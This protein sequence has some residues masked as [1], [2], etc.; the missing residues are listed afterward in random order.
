MRRGAFGGAPIKNAG[1]GRKK[2]RF[3]ASLNRA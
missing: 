1:G 2:A 3:K